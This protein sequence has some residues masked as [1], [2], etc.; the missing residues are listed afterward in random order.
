M[1]NNE[2]VVMLVTMQV[3]RTCGAAGFEVNF[4]TLL[5]AD[6]WMDCEK[7]GDPVAPVLPWV[8]QLVADEIGRRSFEKTLEN[9]RAQRL[10]EAEKKRLERKARQQRSG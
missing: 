6:G 4:E 7:C 3:C 2:P 1:P 10:A 9:M 5:E 8:S